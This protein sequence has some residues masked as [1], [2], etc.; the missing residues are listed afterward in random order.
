MRIEKIFLSLLIIFLFL[1]QGCGKKSPPLPIEKSIPQGADLTLEPTPYGI[2]LWITLPEKTQGGY[3]L[4]KIQYVE[5]EKKEE[6]IEK[7]GKIKIRHFKIKPKL[8]SAGR[9]FLYTD[10]DLKS[11]YKYTYRLRI[12]KDF[13]VATPFL[14]ERVIYWSDPPSWVRDLNLILSSPRELTLKWNPPLFNLKGAPLMGELFYTIE[15]VKNGKIEYLNIR[16]TYFKDKFTEDEKSCYRVR[17][18]LNYYGTF[19]PG[20][21]SEYLCY[22]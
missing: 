5:I 8:H 9:L 20:P 3:T 1:L 17:A 11:G 21:F 2:K 12:K 19:L 13:L 14:P 18:L 10:T 22:P 16:E 7:G 15:R 4:T 6:P